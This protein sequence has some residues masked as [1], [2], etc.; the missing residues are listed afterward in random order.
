MIRPLVALLVQ[1]EVGLVQLLPVIFLNELDEPLVVFVA[2]LCAEGLPKYVRVM[3]FDYAFYGIV[4]IALRLLQPRA[5]QGGK[6]LPPPFV[7]MSAS[8][9]MFRR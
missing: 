4:P 7:R 5:R 1:I 9:G 3:G 6:V 2:V 8:S